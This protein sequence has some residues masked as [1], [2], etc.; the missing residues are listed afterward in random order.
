MGGKGGC[1][2]CLGHS[3]ILSNAPLATE[4]LLGRGRRRSPQEGRRRPQRGGW[5]RRDLE[6]PSAAAVAAAAPKLQARLPPGA[7]VT[8]A[9]DS[10]TSYCLSYGNFLATTHRARDQ[11]EDS[12]GEQSTRSPAPPTPSVLAAYS[13]VCSSTVDPHSP[14]NHIPKAPRHAG[15]QEST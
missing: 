10:G 3:L 1:W 7:L 5:W 14:A 9:D 2:T 4:P 12:K 15:E 11:A 8:F 6:F 13:Q